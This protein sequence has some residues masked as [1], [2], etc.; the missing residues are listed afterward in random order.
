MCAEKYWHCSVMFIV[1]QFICESFS[2]TFTT[3]MR[4]RHK[5]LC[6]LAGA[7][8]LRPAED[9]CCYDIVKSKQGS[10]LEAFGHNPTDAKHIRQTSE[11]VVP[12][13]LSRITIATTHHQ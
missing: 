9:L 12:L 7:G 2:T 3:S 5:R 11:P 8:C 1:H 10:D 6:P 4:P 13:V